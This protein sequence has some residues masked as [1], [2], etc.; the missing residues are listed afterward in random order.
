MLEQFERRVEAGGLSLLGSINVKQT[1]FA[2]ASRDVEINNSIDSGDIATQLALEDMA[3]QYG[4]DKLN[5]MSPEEFYRL[6]RS[7]TSD[8]KA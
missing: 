2:N 6:Y 1:G 7:H 4:A 8:A 5:Q 3:K